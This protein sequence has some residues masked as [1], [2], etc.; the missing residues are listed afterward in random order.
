[1]R[2]VLVAGVQ[3]QKAEHT[4]KR[5]HDEGTAEHRHSNGQARGQ[6][7]PG[8]QGRAVTLRLKQSVIWRLAQDLVLVQT[9]AGDG[10]QVAVRWAGEAVL[11]PRGAAGEADGVAFQAGGV[12]DGQH[13]VVV[14]E[15]GTGAW[16]VSGW[17]V[18]HTAH[19]VQVE[20]GVA[21]CKM[22]RKKKTTL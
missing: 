12:L 16:G 20:P 21:L 2:F 1:M 6:L 19:L 18:S 14:E 22:R 9:G 15:G 8:F 3:L 11:R 5:S 17:T 7:G 10:V 13:L 4:Y